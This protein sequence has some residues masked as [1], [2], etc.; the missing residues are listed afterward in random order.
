MKQA[1]AQHASH[2]RHR[3]KR[4][5]YVVARHQIERL[6]RRARVSAR[7]LREIAG[8]IVADGCYLSL[9]ELRNTSRRPGSFQ[10]HRGEWHKVEKA[11]AVLG[12]RVAGSFHSH[13]V[14]DAT[15]SNG[16]IRGATDG[17]LMLIF[18]A[19]GQ[20]VR[21]WKI[22]KGKASPQNCDIRD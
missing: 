6:F 7:S 15:P 2:H 9:I 5:Q 18:D 10:L 3:T 19:I 8:L 1:A 16:D 21:L 14:S 22:Q 17:D 11:C 4:K 20:A 13:V 12:L